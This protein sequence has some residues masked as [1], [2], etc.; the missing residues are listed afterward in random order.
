MAG[1][2]SVHARLT[3]ERGSAASHRCSECGRP[4]HQWAYTGPRVGGERLP[5]STDL[6][7]YSPMCRSCHRRYDALGIR[8]SDKHPG[9]VPLF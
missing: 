2:A 4:A 3:R 9:D 8:V 7:L 5:F 6:A 1:Y